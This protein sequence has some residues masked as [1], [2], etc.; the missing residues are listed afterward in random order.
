VAL[1]DYIILAGEGHFLMAQILGV[2]VQY[3]L[4][5]NITTAQQAITLFAEIQRSTKLNPNQKVLIDASKDTVLNHC[6]FDMSE[7]PTSQLY[8]R[9]QFSATNHKKAAHCY[10]A[11]FLAST[12]LNH[13]YKPKDKSDPAHTSQLIIDTTKLPDE[14]ERFFRFLDVSILHR[15]PA[16]MGNL[17]EK[18]GKSF[19]AS[20]VSLYRHYPKLIKELDCIM[21]GTLRT[22]MA[23]HAVAT[24]RA[25]LITSAIATYFDSWGLKVKGPSPMPKHSGMSEADWLNHEYYQFQRYLR[26]TGVLTAPALQ[27]SIW[28]PGTT[29]KIAVK[30]KSKA[31]GK[32]PRRVAKKTP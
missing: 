25:K 27:E 20:M 26:I 22:R 2:P 1:P 31:K 10:G 9:I 16:E 23:V 17:N 8:H 5:A 4:H 21:T 14:L 3:E 32:A 19:M 13:L 18:R 15:C 30:G 7:D 11:G 24:S 28:N 29:P 6:I 12:V